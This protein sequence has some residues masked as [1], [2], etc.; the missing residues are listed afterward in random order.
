MSEFKLEELRADPFGF[1]RLQATLPELS[2]AIGEG[3]LKLGELFGQEEVNMTGAPLAHY[4]S[5]EGGRAA[6]ELGFVVPPAAAEPL[7]EVGVEIG[8]TPDGQ[9]L[10]GIHF[11]PYET[12]SQTYDKMGLDLKRRHLE[13]APDMWERYYS[14]LGTPPEKIMTEVIWPIARSA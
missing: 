4:V 13:G 8:H 2:G 3:F 14:P 12:V 9:V 11:G 1:M 6:F 5:F 7:R 10:R